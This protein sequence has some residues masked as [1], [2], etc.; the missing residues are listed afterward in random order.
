VFE[1][2][3]AATDVGDFE[4]LLPWN[5]DRS[6]ILYAAVGDVI[7]LE[8]RDSKWLLADVPRVEGAGIAERAYQRALRY[9]K[10]RVQGNAPVSDL[11]GMD[12]FSPLGVE[13]VLLRPAPVGTCRR[14]PWRPVQGQSCRPS[15]ACRFFSREC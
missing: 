2:L 9:A 7:W 6:K 12:Q 15:V 4:Q 3:P 13:A 11:C 1:Q 14:I 8:W 10:E 5:V